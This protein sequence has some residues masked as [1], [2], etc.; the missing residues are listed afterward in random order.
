VRGTLPHVDRTILAVAGRL[1]PHLENGR[2]VTFWT[3]A[4]RAP[5]MPPE[6]GSS[7]RAF[8]DAARG[9]DGELRSFDPRPEALRIAELVGDECGAVLRT[10]A[11]RLEVPTLPQ[12]P[13]HGDAHLGNVLAG[14]LWLDMDE[15]CLAP[16]EWDLACLRHR[17]FF[18]GEIERETRE[19]LAAYGPYDEAAVEVLER[20]SPD[21]WSS[22]QPEEITCTPMI[23][24]L[25]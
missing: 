24:E 19:A 25:P 5:A 10:A 17:W 8:H 11:A 1:G 14:G 23:R 21:G 15:A 12:Q 4:R 20:R 3:Y 9:F 16:P 13:V 6:A 22:V 18:A 7:L 2:Y